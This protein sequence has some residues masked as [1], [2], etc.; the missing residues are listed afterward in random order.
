MC[1]SQ[2]VESPFASFLLY[3]RF[4][5]TIKVASFLVL[6]PY[7]GAI[8]RG[9][10]GNSFRRAVCAIPRSDCSSCILRQKCLY[11]SIFEPPPPA[12]Y[13]DAAKF[14]RAPAPYVLNPPLTSRQ[15][16]HPEESLD[17]ELVLIGPAIEALPYF[18]Y[19]FIEMGKRGIGPKHG[20]YDLTS[21][22]L[23]REEETPFKVYDGEARMLSAYPPRIPTV[24]IE[25]GNGLNTLTIN[26]LTPLRLKVKGD[27]AT[28]LTFDLFFERLV[29]RLMLLAT[30]Y[31]PAVRLPDFAPLIAASR[32]I[33]E[34]AYD[35]HWY[36]WERYSTRQKETMRFGGLRGKI[37]FSG[38][39]GPF[40]PYLNLGQTIN[41]GQGTT[42]GLGRIHICQND[43]GGMVKLPERP[44]IPTS[45]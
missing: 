22:D 11:V 36:D 38:E 43:F 9:A 21:V 16:F 28:R 15:A 10:F 30:F 7:K 2:P 23:I 42:F 5:F 44:E 27:L 35:L 40:V 12:V 1:I 4:R 13:P 45:A 24:P 17:F 31:N 39:L 26:F 20:K 29:Q 37:S 33:R 19:A 41:V 25:P 14:N 34:T 18:I 3:E 32:D 8:F 6:P